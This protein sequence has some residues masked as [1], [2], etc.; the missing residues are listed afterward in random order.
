MALS[1]HQDA[2]LTAFN[3][4]GLK[5]VAERF[6][7]LTDREQLAPLLAFIDENKLPVLWLGGGSNLVLAPSVPGLVVRVELSGI[8]IESEDSDSVLLRV[9]AGENWHQLVLYCLNK[10]L[11]GLE[12]L[13]LIPG[14]VGA[15]PVQNIGAY[16]VEV[17]ELI[18]SV[19]VLNLNTG[20]I[21]W[22][23][24]QACEFGYRDSVFKRNPGHY[25]ILSVRFRLA[26]QFSPDVA[27]AALSAE[28]KARG[29][30]TPSAAE[31]V[32]AVCA[33]RS[34]KL[35]DP[36]VLG[37]AGSFFKNP[38]VSDALYEALKLEYPDM[39][40]YPDA[41]GHKLA[42][43]WLLDR[44]GWKGSTVGKVGMHADQALVLVNRGGADR[45][46]VEHLAEQI[47]ASVLDQFGVS[48][49]QEP[50]P[51]P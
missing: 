18:E 27:Y 33:V 25:L 31:L 4:L 42:A 3:T 7:H 29:I 23:S 47:K 40:G 15:A 43:G 20:E 34:S 21:S 30:S 50:I 46:D 28:L 5:T 11:H 6:F 26:K 9:Q 45:Q 17:K 51:Y 41:S 39:P 13:A 24:E 10:N 8:E 37:N 12:N 36:A 32:D 19:E 14:T 22:L 1:L 44:A 49:E 2:S 38:V 16:G 35:P 48:L